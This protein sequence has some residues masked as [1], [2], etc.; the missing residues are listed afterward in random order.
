M[1][2]TTAAQRKARAKAEYDAFLAVCPSRKLLDRL[3]DKWVTLV[4]CALGSGPGG[5]G[6]PRPMRYSELSRLLAGVS[7]K[8]LTQTLRS[9]E[10]DGL[11]QHRQSAVGVGGRSQDEGAG[12][13]HGAVSEPGDGPVAERPGAAG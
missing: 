10:R 13:L 9:L 3:S 1:A 12:E 6:E 7:Q 4:L 11:A 2:T 8:M 5:A